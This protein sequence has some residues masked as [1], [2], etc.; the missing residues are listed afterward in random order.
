MINKIYH[1]LI[2]FANCFFYFIFNTS[3]KSFNIDRKFY[4][5]RN[6]LHFRAW[7]LRDV[8]AE[9]FHHSALDVSRPRNRMKNKINTVHGLIIFTFI[10]TS[11]L[12]FSKIIKLCAKLFF[13]GPTLCFFFQ[14]FCKHF[15]KST[16]TKGI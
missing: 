4:Q 5:F 14:T 13:D 7:H 15:R 3:T 2:C 6:I 1:F 12:S 9:Q 11:I 8:P 16:R 10:L